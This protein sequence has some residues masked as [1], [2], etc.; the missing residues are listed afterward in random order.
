VCLRVLKSEVAHASVPRWHRRLW[1][2]VILTYT[3]AIRTT[4]IRQRRIG[5]AMLK[6]THYSRIIL[7]IAP[8]YVA[9][10]SFRSRCLSVDYRH[11]RHCLYMLYFANVRARRLVLISSGFRGARTPPPP[12]RQT[13]AVTH[14]HISYNAK[15]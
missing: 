10:W 15:V 6:T 9:A 7:L 13:D 12:G 4:E 11:Y 1:V 5:Y 8:A 14:G 2:N 3:F